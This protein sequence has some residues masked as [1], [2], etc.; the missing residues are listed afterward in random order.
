MPVTQNKSGPYAPASALLDVVSRYRSRGLP[1][2]VTGEVLA[3]AGISESLIPRTLQALQTLDLI[4]EDGHPTQ[5][6]DSLRLAPEAEFSDRLADWLRA[7]YADVFTFVD[8]SKDDSTRIRDAFRSYQP[9]GQQDRMVSLFQGLC[10]A[11]GLMPEKTA[12]PSPN[13]PTAVRPRLRL[14]EAAARRATTSSRSPAS[15]S[16]HQNGGSVGP[17]ALPAPIAGLLASLPPEGQ[18]WTTERRDKFLAAFG[19][20]ID[21][22]FPVVAGP[23][24]DDEAA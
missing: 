24:P 10:A 16:Q 17:T 5:T 22:C 3:R 11:A 23:E 12:K 7:A 20:V 4:N 2:P 13:R 1:V 15:H 18:G 9:I 19:M 6:L 14:S 8:P 21:F